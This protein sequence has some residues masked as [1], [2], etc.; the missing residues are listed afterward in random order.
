M[1]IELPLR[2]LDHAQLT[3]AALAGLRAHDPLPTAQA[4]VEFFDAA[5]LEELR[6]RINRWMT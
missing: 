2:E 1:A 5:G 3:L 6:Q 4:L